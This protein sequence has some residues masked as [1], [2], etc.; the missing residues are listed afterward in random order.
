MSGHFPGH[1]APPAVT[2]FDP[3]VWAPVQST[4][5]C[6]NPGMTSAH[7]SDSGMWHTKMC[8]SAGEVGDWARESYT[9]ENS[10][11][12]SWRWWRLCFLGHTM[13]TGTFP[14]RCNWAAE[15]GFPYMAGC[16]PYINKQ[17]HSKKHMWSDNDLICCSYRTL[18]GLTQK[19]TSLITANCRL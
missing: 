17:T 13:G 8:C 16:K 18:N 15:V 19:Y 12:T 10:R 1:N 3:Y 14:P 5:E 6:K 2:H 11:M 7:I 4:A 9:L